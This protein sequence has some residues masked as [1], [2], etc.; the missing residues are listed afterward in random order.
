MRAHRDSVRALPHREKRVRD[1]RLRHK[2]RRRPAG[3]KIY[4]SLMIPNHKPRD[5]RVADGGGLGE[6]RQRERPHRVQRVE[7]LGLGSRDHVRLRARRRETLAQIISDEKMRNRDP[8]SW[9]CQK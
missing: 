4:E 5:R 2:R 6:S 3:R 1:V 7:A 9:L 8:T